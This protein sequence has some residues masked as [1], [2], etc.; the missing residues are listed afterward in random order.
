MWL[1]YLSLDLTQSHIGHLV[2]ES[3]SLVKLQCLIVTYHA[4]C[5]EIHLLREV[6]EGPER[7]NVHYNYL[8]T[9]VSLFEL[10]HRKTFFHILKVL[11]V[12]FVSFS[13]MAECTFIF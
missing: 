1:I 7:I 6:A 13:E 5:V 10:E 11:L 4:L 12:D 9:W 2:A 8:L 3:P